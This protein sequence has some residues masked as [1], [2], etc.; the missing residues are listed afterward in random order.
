[1]GNKEEVERQYNES[2]GEL[3]QLKAEL[4]ICATAIKECKDKDERA[5]LFE[6]KK[7]IQSD[8]AEMEA[9]IKW[10]EEQLSPGQ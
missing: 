5:E 1:M 10:F 9:E 8:I 3:K 7:Q 2:K 4:I 6:E